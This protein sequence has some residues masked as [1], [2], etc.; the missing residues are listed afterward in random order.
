MQTEAVS[1]A[2][3]R[4]ARVVD[5]FTDGPGG[6]NPAPIVVDARGMDAEAMQA[7]AQ[8][9]GL[10]SGFV[11]AAPDGSGCDL[12][13]RFWVPRHEMTMCGHATVGAV[14]LLRELGRIEGDRHRV[15]TRSGVVDCRTH[16]SGDDTF[17][18]I[19]QPAG[20][21]DV[22]ASDASDEVYDVLGLDPSHR[23]AAVPVLNAAT[24]RVKTLVAVPDIET[25]DRL[26]PDLA[27][28]EDLCSRIGSTGLYPWAPGDETP[29][30][31]DARQFP[32]ASGYPEDAATGIAA[33]ALAYGLHRLDPALVADQQVRVRQGRAMGRPSLITVRF[34]GGPDDGCWVGGAVRL[35][36][37]AP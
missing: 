27:R 30:T 5:V 36:D 35:H 20:R 7:V 10:E 34:D 17:T 18:E 9:H 2:Q 22:L 4:E 23:P 13:L 6:G 12:G 28:I 26:Q 11:V 3:E 21:V 16:G 31:F 32:A 1:G 33:A 25:L 14:W 19:S 24:A 8:A 29:G 37:P 15:W